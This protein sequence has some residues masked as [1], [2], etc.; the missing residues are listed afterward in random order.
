MS[1]T[2]VKKFK[3]RLLTLRDERDLTQA[4]LA[5]RS[6]LS[7]TYIHQLEKGVKIPSLVTLSLLAD[8]LGTEIADL[9][10][11]PKMAAPK[12]DKQ[13]EEV[14]LLTQAVQHEDADTVKWLRQLIQAALKHPGAKR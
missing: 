13:S 10:E 1:G 11:F 3:E 7:A 2:I 14:F 5:K 9:V 8:G 12:R 4:E 6:H